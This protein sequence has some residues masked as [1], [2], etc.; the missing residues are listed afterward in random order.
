LFVTPLISPLRDGLGQLTNIH[1]SATNT[2]DVSFAYDRLGR[3]TTIAGGQGTRTFTY[4]D[5]LQLAS[6]LSLIS[7]QQF[8]ITRQYDAY[9]TPQPVMLTV[10][11]PIGMTYYHPM[12]SMKM[13]GRMIMLEASVMLLA[14]PIVGHAQLFPFITNGSAITGDKGFGSDKIISVPAVV[15]SQF[16]YVT[17]GNTVTLTKYT[18]AGSTVTIPGTIDDLPVTSIGNG[19]FSGCTRLSNVTIGKNVT[20]IGSNAFADCT[21]LFT[22]MIGNNVTYIG[23]WAFHNCSRLNNLTLGNRVAY[24][25]EVAFAHCTSLTSVTVPSS[26]RSIGVGAFSSCSSLASVTIENGVTYIGHWAFNHCTSLSRM[27]IP[28]SVTSIGYKAFLDCTS[29]T[30]VTIGY[31]VRSIGDWAFA[32]CTSLTS[33]NFK[34]NTPGLDKFVFYNDDK[35]LSNTR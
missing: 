34:G 5:A 12:A 29:L 22:V 24:I 15:P 10:A 3:Q 28:D 4:N 17:N 35:Y 8:E 33:V 21:S 1:Y 13:I 31:G 25:G 11:S 30:S 9:G 20:S 14:M 2:P 6:E 27:T 18:G 16:T 32:G 7:N 26:V 23:D 19:A